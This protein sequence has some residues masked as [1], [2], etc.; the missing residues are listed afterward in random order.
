MKRTVTNRWP[1]RSTSWFPVRTAGACTAVGAPRNRAGL[2][3]VG[4]NSKRGEQCGVDVVGDSV[5]SGSRSTTG[6]GDR[7]CERQAGSQH[8]SQGGIAA[9]VTAGA[10]VSSG[11]SSNGTSPQQDGQRGGRRVLEER[12]QYSN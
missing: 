12:R 1:S 10:A 7:H 8:R 9:A 5:A 11:S 2:L 4:R 3:L 6:S